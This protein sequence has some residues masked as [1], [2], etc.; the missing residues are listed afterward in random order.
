MR[1][2]GVALEAALWMPN[3]STY[4]TTIYPGRF[5]N[6]TRLSAFRSRQQVDLMWLPSA[7]VSIC[8]LQ[9]ISSADGISSTATRPKLPGTEAD[10]RIEFESTQAAT[11]EG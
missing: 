7:M 6:I 10:G 1:L 5:D 9:K 3:C 11:Q 4:N 8:F 2:C